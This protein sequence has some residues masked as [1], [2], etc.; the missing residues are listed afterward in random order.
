MVLTPISLHQ[1]DLKVEYFVQ[2]ANDVNLYFNYATHVSQPDEVLAK[3]KAKAVSAFENV[4]KRLNEEY[5]KFCA[6]SQ[7][8]FQ[9]LPWEVN[10]LT[11]EELYYKVRSEMGEKIDRII[12]EVTQQLPDQ[13][14]LSLYL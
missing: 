3:C 10:V 6:L 14:I 4:I 13:K 1:R 5:E 11:Y 8:P 7:I 2:T 9:K 12:Q